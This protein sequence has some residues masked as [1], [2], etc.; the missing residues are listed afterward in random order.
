M[1]L[2]RYFLLLRLL[3]L[4]IVVL[5]PTLLFAA[6]AFVREGHNDSSAATTLTITVTVD[7]G[8][9]VV[10]FFTGSGAT[11]T[12]TSVLDNNSVAYTSLDVAG[13]NITTHKLWAYGLVN[14][15]AATSIIV[16]YSQAAVSNGMAL[17]Y[18]GVSSF[19]NEAENTNTSSTNPTV[20]VT[21]QD[22]NNFVACGM[23]DA[24]GGGTHTAQNGTIRLNA[25]NLN[26]ASSQMTGV[27]NTAASPG[28]VTCSFT[29]ASAV[30]F[31]AIGIELRDEVVSSGVRRRI[32]FQ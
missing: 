32:I 18:S 10:I 19:G 27:D 7:A 16:T 25:Y 3:P 4:F 1:R 5:Y 30:N 15:P 20:S 21:T 8:N 23:P 24:A 6:V 9:D 29:T 26:Q 13:D 28:S 14:A 12:I 31:T 2:I 22:N 11:T 17:V